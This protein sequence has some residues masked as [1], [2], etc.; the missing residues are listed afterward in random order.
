MDQIIVS[1]MPGYRI[2]ATGVGGNN[3]GVFFAY[4]DEIVSI[5]ASYVGNPNDEHVDQFDQMVNSITV[6]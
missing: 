6:N 4:G 2:V 3:L 1:G 5:T